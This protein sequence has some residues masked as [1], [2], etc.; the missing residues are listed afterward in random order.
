MTCFGLLEY[1]F[2][3]YSIN[4]DPHTCM[5]IHPYKHTHAHPILMST[6]ERLRR[7]N[8]EI[9]TYA[10]HTLMSTSERL[11]RLNLEIYEVDHQE[12]LTVDRDVTSY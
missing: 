7:L 12:R 5:S 2:E 9:H 1:F 10:H 8:F 6:S 4:V 11:S 3:K